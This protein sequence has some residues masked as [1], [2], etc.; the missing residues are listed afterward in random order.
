MLGKEENMLN[1]DKSHDVDWAI[2]GTIA[3]VVWMLTQL[4]TPWWS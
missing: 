2:L 3:L 1:K 4:P